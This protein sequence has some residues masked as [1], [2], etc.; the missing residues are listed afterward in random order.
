MPQD[1]DR[2]VDR[3]RLDRVG[4]STFDLLFYLRRAIS[5]PT[6][7]SCVPLERD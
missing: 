7:G 5:P 6:T 2:L 4:V 1:L 3:Q